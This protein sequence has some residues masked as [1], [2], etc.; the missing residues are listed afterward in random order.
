MTQD[1][2]KQLWGVVRVVASA[3]MLVVLLPRAANYMRP[4]LH[5]STLAW[6]A[7]AVAVT[8]VGVGLATLRWHR[9]LA[10]LDVRNT[11]ISTLLSHYL[12]GLFVS[13]FLPTTIGG[14]VLR[15]S[16]LA[17]GNGESPRSFASVVLERLTGWLVLPVISLV[18]LAI[19]PGLLRPPIDDASH[20]VVVISLVTLSLLV[21]LLVGASSP[22]LGR[23]LQTHTG[24]LRFV[25][26]IH[27][28]L[29]R[30]RRSP[31]MAFEVLVAG[32]AYQLAVVFAAFLSAKALGLPVSWTAVL[33]FVPAVA[34]VQVLPL[35]L[36]GLGLR[37]AAYVLFLRPLDVPSGRAVALG[38]LLYGLNLTVSL[39]GAPSFAVGGKRRRKVLT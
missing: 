8:L 37:E 35:S 31:G 1:R 20:L 27:L 21:V 10:A 2:R 29:A 3:A 17:A 16:R 15:V 28:G 25:N 36:G 33:A 14:D 4:V 39:V 32:F 5:L 11:R 30:F 19:N 9:V 38:L 34:I 22:R 24:W 23:R 12:A 6:L 18:T 7:A 26:A 13:N